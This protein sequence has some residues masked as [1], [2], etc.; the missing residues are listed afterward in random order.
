MMYKHLGKKV[1]NHPSTETVKRKS[2][3]ISHAGSLV[4][5]LNSKHYTKNVNNTS[6]L[7]LSLSCEEIKVPN[8]HCSLGD[9]RQKVVMVNEYP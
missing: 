1:T 8:N 4:M 6:G 3:V 5:L 9:R 2:W 7:T